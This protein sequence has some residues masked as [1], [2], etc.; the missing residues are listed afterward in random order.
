[1]LILIT[2]LQFQS[3]SYIMNCKIWYLYKYIYVCSIDSIK[4]GY[5]TNSII[6]KGYNIYHIRS[7]N[8][9]FRSIHI[10]LMSSNYKYIPYTNNTTIIPEIDKL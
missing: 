3:N 1:M 6:K 5:Y 7:H 4:F 9:I 8:K 10:S 2:L